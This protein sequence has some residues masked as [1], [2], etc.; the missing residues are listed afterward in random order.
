MISSDIPLV[1]LG[2]SAFVGRCFMRRLSASGLR[3]EAVSRRALDVPEGFTAIQADLNSPGDWKPPPGAVIVSFL[4]LWIL[5]GFLTRFSGAS[6]IVAVGS[7]SRYAKAESSDAH[8]RSI[9]ELLLDAEA[10]LEAW[11]RKNGV[12]WTILRPTLVY[13]CKNDKNITRMARFIRRWRFLPLAAPAKGLRQP[14][15]ADDV[16]GA[17]LACLDNPAASGKAFNISGGEV[18]SYREMAERV[19]TALGQKPRFVMLPVNFLKFAFKAAAWAGLADGS[20]FS[21]AVFSA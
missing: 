14:I 9:A 15:H 19:F 5:T 17:A 12:G 20:N 10:A 8:E 1:I 21:A 6:A 16:V 7:T 2:G 3:A 18:L 13:D 4:P 11:A